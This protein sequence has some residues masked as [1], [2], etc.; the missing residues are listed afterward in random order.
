MIVCAGGGHSVLS[1]GGEDHAVARWLADNGIAALVLKYRL[2]REKGSPYK[3]DT[4]ALQDGGLSNALRFAP[5]YN[6]LMDATADAPLVEPE[7]GEAARAPQ[8]Q[9]ELHFVW[10]SFFL[11]APRHHYSGKA[12]ER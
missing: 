6:L 5:G 2:A 3:I 11:P 7:G 1:V 10:A 8:G 4:H 9:K 12:D